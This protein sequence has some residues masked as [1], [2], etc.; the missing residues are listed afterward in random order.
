MNQFDTGIK[1]YVGD[2]KATAT[3]QLKADDSI[4]ND[5]GIFL[6]DFA[7][8][9]TIGTINLVPIV[10]GGSKGALDALNDCNLD[11]A[12]IHILGGFSNGMTTASQKAI[13]E[14]V[15]IGLKGKM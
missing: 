3:D 6:K 5:L 9:P 2:A 4:F 1:N 11:D 7:I 12:L 13:A 10:I 15:I 14:A 8:P